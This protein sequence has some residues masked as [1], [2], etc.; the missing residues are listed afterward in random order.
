M[1][2]HAL[3]RRW[4]EHH[5]QGLVPLLVLRHVIVLGRLVSWQPHLGLVL[6]LSSL[7]TLHGW[8]QWVAR[9]CRRCRDDAGWEEV[10]ASAAAAPRP[11]R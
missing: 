8:L 7:A 9:W 10:Q 11:A 2:P 1:P 3:V 4:V 5:L 6:P